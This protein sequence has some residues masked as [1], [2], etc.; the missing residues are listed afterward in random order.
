[1]LLIII[2]QPKGISNSLALCPQNMLRLIEVIVEQIIKVG[3]I[4]SHR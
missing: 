3:S 1:M 4:F 2:A